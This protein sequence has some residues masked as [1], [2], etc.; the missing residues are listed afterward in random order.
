ML[1]TVILL[2]IAA[3][4]RVI[5]AK[6]GEQLL[7]APGETVT[8]KVQSDFSNGAVWYFVGPEKGPVS[9]RNGATGTFAASES[10]LPGTPGAQL[11][12]LECSSTA[13]EGDLNAFMLV[14]RV[15]WKVEDTT[16]KELVIRVT[17]GG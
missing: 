10:G 8:L 15:S 5:E 12:S 7:C 9:L 6:E 3:S 13:R 17:S 11:F 4:Q 14:N 16:A 2:S 1:F